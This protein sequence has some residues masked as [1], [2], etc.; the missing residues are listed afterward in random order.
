MPSVSKKTGDETLRTSP[1]TPFF[2]LFIEFGCL[3]WDLRDSKIRSKSGGRDSYLHKHL[4][5]LFLEYVGPQQIFFCRASVYMNSVSHQNLCNSTSVGPVSRD[6][7]KE[8]P[9]DQ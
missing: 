5:G 7:T 8:I 1:A 6:P 2:L 9:I 4:T 3:L